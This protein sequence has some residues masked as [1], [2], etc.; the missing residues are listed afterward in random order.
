MD[1]P[2]ED[3]PVFADERQSKIA[4]LVAARGKVLTSQLTTL[5]G[6]SEPTLRKDLTVL[7]Q[8]GLLKRTH[9]G[10]VAIRPPV[11]RELEVR[12]TQN[13]SAKQAIA[14]ACLREINNGEA[15]FLDSGTTVQ[16]VAQELGKSR[17]QLTVVTNAPRAAMEIAANSA[18]SH[19][20]L[21]GQLRLVSGSI[22]GPL[23]TQLLGLFRINVA[24]I[25]VSGITEDGI[26]VSDF[27]EAQLK[28]A[29]IER[30]QK[31]IV[32]L[33]HTKI[34]VVDFTKVCGLDQI[35]VVVTDRCNETL[36]KLCEERGI[37]V[38]V[39]DSNSVS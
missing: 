27:A 2:M 24:L 26:T 17:R 13:H 12:S 19:I 9:G 14:V 21:G 7:E 39:A 36:Q 11:E 18:I 34:G 16:L 32:P 38:V 33:D 25:G 20:L 22:T 4:E 23:T 35:D 28:A 3:T 8:R 6:V 30:A 37:R 31:V 29:V 15:V 1:H 10:A 5:L